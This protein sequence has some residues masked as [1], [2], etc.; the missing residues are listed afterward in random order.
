[1]NLMTRRESVAL[2]T[3]GLSFG[4]IGATCNHPLQAKEKA[5]LPRYKRIGIAI[6]PFSG[7]TVNQATVEHMFNATSA[8]LSR[9]NHFTILDRSS[10]PDLLRQYR[11]GDS[12][13]MDEDTVKEFEKVKGLEYILYG[14]VDSVLINNSLETSKD[15]VAYT[16]KSTVKVTYRLVNLATAKTETA[17]FEAIGTQTSNRGYP[18]GNATAKAIDKASAFAKEFMRSVSPMTC[19]IIE[20]NPVEKY[21]RV[22]IGFDEGVSDEMIFTVSA[23]MKRTLPSGAEIEEETVIAYGRPIPGQTKRGW[24]KLE[25]VEWGK[26]GLGGGGMG[27][28]PVLQQL[29]KDRLEKLN[30]G[31]KEKD[32][33]L[34]IE[35]GQVAHT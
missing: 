35:D 26:T 5:S 30:R 9:S 31:R 29:D 27:W 22:D 18:E 3:L 8:D 6:Y 21:F 20:V 16:S 17:Q 24:A 10:F 23:S 4:L 1:M 19:K 25:P 28:R 7:R 15:S 11:I 14:S 12:G 32:V 34:I 2:L 13:L 33:K